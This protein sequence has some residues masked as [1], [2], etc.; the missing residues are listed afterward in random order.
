MRLNTGSANGNVTPR[1]LSRV[2]RVLIVR[3][4]GAEPLHGYRIIPGPRIAIANE[5]IITTELPADTSNAFIS[6]TKVET[7]T[8]TYT[9]N[10]RAGCSAIFGCKPSVLELR[11]SFVNYVMKSIDPSGAIELPAPKSAEG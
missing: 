11:A 1:S 9:I 2:Q 6:V 4:N 10:F 5:T 3:Q 8:G 7:D